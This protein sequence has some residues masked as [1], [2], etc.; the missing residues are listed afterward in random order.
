MCVLGPTASGKTGLAVQLCQ[1][2]GYE[3]I[4]VDSALVYRQMDIGTAK[5]GADVLR[6]APHALINLVDPWQSYSVARFLVDVDLQIERIAK[7][8]RIPLLTGGTMLY[9]KALWDGLS[10][11]PE[12][13]ESVRQKLQQQAESQGWQK[14]HERL[15]LVD[16]PSAGRIHPNDPQ[17]LLRALEVFEISGVPLSQ[18]QN[19]KTSNPRYDFYNIGLFPGDR[20]LLHSRIAQRFGEML[21]QGFAREVDSLMQQPQMHVELSS[22]RCV[23]YR[24][25]WSHLAGDCNHTQMTEQALAA[26]RQLAKRQITWMR[27]MDNLQLMDV[28]SGIADLVENE[29]Y[30]AWS[31]R[32]KF[33]HDQ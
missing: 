31:A 22:M 28:P 6:L 4:S 24:Q 8:G 15:A 10:V 32:Y 9:Y 29:R 20:A 18:L 19:H 1:S 3:I 13:D 25:M 27:R 23:G 5:P 33:I 17:R 11:L 30:K 21:E 16:A 7:A 14:M 12:S 2:G 26:T